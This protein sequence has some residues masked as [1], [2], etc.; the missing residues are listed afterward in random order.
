MN[1]LTL[2][3]CFITSYTVVLPS[4]S[5]F[6]KA[7]SPVSGSTIKNSRLTAEESSVMWNLVLLCGA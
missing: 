1:I 6:F 3:Y 5:D 2:F 4:N 7:T